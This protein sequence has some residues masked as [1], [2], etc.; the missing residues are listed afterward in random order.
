MW[1]YPHPWNR[2]NFCRSS[3]QRYISEQ[4]LC[5][6]QLEL[7]AFH[8]TYHFALTQSRNLVFSVK[9]AEKGQHI[10]CHLKTF[11]ST[12]LLNTSENSKCIMKWG[13]KTLNTRY[14]TFYVYSSKN[15]TTSE[16][17]PSSSS[18]FLLLF[19]SLFAKV[20]TSFHLLSHH[21]PEMNKIQKTSALIMGSKCLL[22]LRWETSPSRWVL[23]QEFAD[24][25]GKVIYYW[26]LF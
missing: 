4:V 26:D 7:C 13:N 1:I 24:R 15:I 3:S 25:E 12:S 19:L 8:H 10:T 9:W 18:W 2:T 5:Y 16:T 6:S 21:L 14:I 11:H 20:T 22:T 23:R 17:S